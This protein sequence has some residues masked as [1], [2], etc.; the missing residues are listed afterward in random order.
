L[1]V[2]GIICGSC[3]CW[4]VLTRVVDYF[5]KDITMHV[6]KVI[7]KAAGILIIAFGLIAI[8]YLR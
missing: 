6:Q 2:V 8:V 7:N 1:L 4:Y 5:R 3:V